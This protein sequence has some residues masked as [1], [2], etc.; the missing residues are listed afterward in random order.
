MFPID[1]IANY[2]EIDP[3]S[4]SHLRWKKDVGKIL[5]AGNPAFNTPSGRCGYFQGQL[6]GKKYMAHRIVF[7]LANGRWPKKFVDH[8]DGNYQNNAPS[9]LRDVTN[10]QNLQ[11][12]KGAKGYSKMYN[13]KF[14]VTIKN[15]KTGRYDYLGLCETEEEAKK[16][17]LEA[18]RVIHPF[19]V[20]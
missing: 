18:K 11:N 7:F 16:R 12:M 19:F 8:I 20:E 6:F 15:P 10:A 13:G 14:R 5:K 9:N 1:Q 2:V 17:Y 3:T 4:R